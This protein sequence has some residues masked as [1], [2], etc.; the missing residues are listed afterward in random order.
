MG[1]S[2][3]VPQGVGVDE[4][5]TDSEGL[6]VWQVVR[7]EVGVNEAVP[8]DVKD[9]DK[10]G[11]GVAER[12]AEPL[13]DQLPEGV[14]V[15]LPVTEAVT[16]ALWETLWEG[17]VVV[18]YVGMPDPLA[19]RDTVPLGLEVTLGDADIDAV[20][21]W[22]VLGEGVGEMELEALCIP[23][24]VSESVAEELVD[25]EVTGEEVGH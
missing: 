12:L 5:D 21:H 19:V 2:L 24:G 15:P 7:L 20:P 13:T 23:E 4:L 16:K 14:R 6:L 3:P 9:G 18:L 22:E 11:E 8:H 10:E 25:G 1:G 17:Q